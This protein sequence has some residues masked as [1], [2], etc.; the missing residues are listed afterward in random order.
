MPDSA[1]RTDQIPGQGL[2]VLAVSLYLANLLVLPGIAFGALV[3]LELR[4]H[5]SAPPLARQHLAQS[6]AA[7]LWAGLLLVLMNLLILLLGGYQAVQ[8][9]IILILYFT[10]V[11]ASLVLL[12]VVA[13]SKALAGQTWAMPLIGRFPFLTD[14]LGVSR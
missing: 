3:W 14:R 9:W 2:A 10:F 13:L 4:R 11:H 12:G 6:L 8:T 5:R 7:S 1:E